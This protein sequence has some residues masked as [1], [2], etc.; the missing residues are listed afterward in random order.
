M[1][2]RKTVL[3]LG[4][5]LLLTGFCLA[6]TLNS[7]DQIVAT[8][9][10]APNSADLLWFFNNNPVTVSGTPILTLTLYNG[11][12]ALGSIVAPPFVFGGNSY[13]QNFFEKPGSQ[14]N[15]PAP[16]STFVDFTS[17]NNGTIAGILVWTVSGGSLSGFNLSDFILY[18]GISATPDSFA[19]QGD[20]NFQ[21]S[22]QP[23]PEPS[24]LL[25]LGTGL[26]G[27]AGA[28]RRRLVG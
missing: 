18:D 4:A 13:F 26:V 14:Y 5:T 23:I 28:V 27:L 22:L 16:P 3:A 21:I 24:S 15:N 8:F 17:I 11:G 25:L 1:T 9:T 7:G 12:T 19:P 10:A 20:I 2:M 6:D